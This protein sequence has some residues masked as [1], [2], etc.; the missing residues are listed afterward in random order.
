V[1]S[2]LPGLLLLPLALTGC[3]CFRANP[4]TGK[5][6]LSFFTDADEIALG[7]GAAPS[8]EQEMG[9]LYRDPALESYIS[10]VGA[11]LAAAS[12]R[13]GIPYRYRVLDSGVV[14]AFA[15]PGGFIYISRGL[16]VRLK[17]ESE[18]AA[19]L[20]H[21]TGHVAARHGVKHLQLSMG[22]NL[23]LRVG[24]EAAAGRGAGAAGSLELARVVASLGSLKY[25]RDDER[26]SDHL[27]ITYAERAGW[28]PRGMIGLMRVLEASEKGSAGPPA[29]LR[30]HPL[31][32]ERIRNAEAE[33]AQRDAGSMDRSVRN[34]P[35]F[36]RQV[37][38]L[39]EFQN[40]QEKDDQA[41]VL[42]SKAKGPN[43]RARRLQ[44]ALVVSNQAVESRPRY[45]PF[46]ATRAM[47]H[48]AL[49][50]DDADPQVLRAQEDARQAVA[51]DGGNF[52]AQFTLG[53]SCLKLGE[54]PQ[55]REALL[56]A[57]AIWPAHPGPPYGLGQ[58]AER[59][60]RRD[61]AL[62]HYARASALDPEGTGY[63]S[64]ADEAARRLSAP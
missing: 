44:Q 42:L 32:S 62:S 2:R 28:D 48:L 23:L 12:D 37:A 14:N 47:I 58:A 39:R 15:L 21:E 61:E 56:K 49:S 27:G 9:G 6:E 40:A 60:G 43:E 31:S 55:A 26:E 51:L 7:A 8:M 10:S 53:L 36:D 50:Q 33:L 19:V 34:T 35:E 22:L 38:A 30:T 17:D 5:T 64:L 3:E 13:K 52:Q 63:G 57:S 1:R 11:R 54:A 46:R 45:A 25:T 18:L 24:A 16:L 59:Q 4:V 29:I 20:G 41:R